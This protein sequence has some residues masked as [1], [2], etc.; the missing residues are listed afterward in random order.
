MRKS[1]EDLVFEVEEKNYTPLEELIEVAVQY[2]KN[3]KVKKNVNKVFKIGS[4]KIKGMHRGTLYHIMD[5]IEKEYNLDVSYNRRLGCLEL[6]SKKSLKIVELFG[7]IGAPLLALNY[8]GVP[9]DVVDYIEIDKYAYE[10][11]NSMH[12]SQEIARD[13]KE[14]SPTYPKGEI[15]IMFSGSPCQDFSVAG[16]GLGGEKDSGT[17]SS[18]LWETVRIAKAIRPKFVVFE[19]VAAVV[20]KRHKKVFDE[21]LNEMELLGYQNN[22]EIISPVYFDV[23]QSRDRVF[24][25]FY[26]DGYD[27][28]F[29]PHLAK[30][31]RTITLQDILEEEYDPVHNLTPTAVE[32][33]IRN[34]Y[35]EH[36]YYNKISRCLVSKYYKKGKNN[37]YV[38]GTNGIKR[39][40]TPREA[41]RLMSIRDEDYDRLEA[42]LSNTRLYQV[43]GNSINVEVMK[44]VVWPIC[45]QLLDNLE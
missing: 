34:G 43:L 11:Y 14:Y 39:A 6:V 35:K 33:N 8:L 23:P 25:V 17:R 42:V 38:I 20:N 3:N 9:T 37:Q 27:Y 16:H 10:G 19:N 41:A 45:E 32:R 28:T 7:G 13:I 36:W 22:Y 12:G 40:L 5:D 2:A 44:Q 26:L 4:T 21:F 18:L 30:E 1:L 31:D 29:V 24:V 15:D